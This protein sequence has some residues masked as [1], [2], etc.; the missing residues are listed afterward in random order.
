MEKKLQWQKKSQAIDPAP[1]DDYQNT[2]S[3]L[4][5]SDGEEVNIEK[6]EK[7]ITKK[8]KDIKKDKKRDKKQ[9]SHEGVVNFDDDE[10]KPKKH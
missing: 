4:D 3:F 9:K 6:R 2:V 8:S 1:K 7:Q 10:V 5:D